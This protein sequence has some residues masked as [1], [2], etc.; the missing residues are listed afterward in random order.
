MLLFVLLLS[1]LTTTK[2]DGCAIEDI[3]GMKDELNTT[4]VPHVASVSMTPTD[5]TIGRTYRIYTV[6][7]GCNLA[8]FPNS[9]A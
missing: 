7:I 8:K 6:S 9:Q 3:G 4:L 1:N 2:A 5:T